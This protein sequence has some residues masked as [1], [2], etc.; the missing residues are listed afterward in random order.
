MTL[1]SIKLLLL[2]PS[3]INHVTGTPQ[4]SYIIGNSV[5][6]WCE[7]YTRNMFFRIVKI[8]VSGA[9]RM[10]IWLNF[11]KTIIT[12][13]CVFQNITYMWIYIAC[14]G[15]YLR[16]YI[17]ALRKLGIRSFDFFMNF[18]STSLPHPKKCF[19]KMCVCVCVCVC[20][21][22]WPRRT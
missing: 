15:S 8:L 22:V 10:R 11:L 3:V 16:T 20:L 18:D 9:K 5:T 17:F 12:S 21:S 2:R 1:R 6:N 19:R 14:L 13:L 7:K 4:Q